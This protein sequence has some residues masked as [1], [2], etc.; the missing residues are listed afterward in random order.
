[1]QIRPSIAAAF[2]FASSLGVCVIAGQTGTLEVSPEHPAIQYSTRETTDAVAALNRRLQAG[3][4]H[5]TFDG[6]RGY[7]KSVL[8]ALDVPVAS[9]TLVFSETSLQYQHINAAN[10]RALYFN[11]RLAVGWVRGADSVELAA[12]DPQQGVVFYTLDQKPASKP[13]FARSQRCLECHLNSFTGNV[14]G[15]VVMSMLPLSDD[16]NEYAR[17]WYVDHRTPIED[18]WGGWYVTGGKVPRAHLGNVPVYHVERSYTRLAVA[19]VLPSV[20]GKFDATEYLSPYSDVIALLVLNH[21][22]HMTNLLTRIGWEARVAAHQGT[23]V[24]TRVRETARELVDYLLFI[25]EA[26]LPGSVS[27]ASGFAEQFSAGGPRDKMGR[28]LRQLDLE[29]RLFRYPCSYMVYTPAFDALP[30]AARDAV[31]AR[32]WEVLSGRDKDQ[33]YDRLSP[34]DRQAIV[35]ILRDTKTGLPDYFAPLT[36]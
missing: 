21:Q 12:Q 32:M 10:P 24:E 25:D 30:L 22:V 1:M 27:G 5:L 2:A 4:L 31:Y 20:S 35:E 18:R 19:P 15:T 13:Q 6:P 26:P 11:D 9:Q 28:S 14:P 7:L 34:A 33:S 36:R 8:D 23:P 16:V 29:R 17:G 3:E